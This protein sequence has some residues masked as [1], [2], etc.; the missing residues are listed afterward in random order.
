[1]NAGG[2]AVTRGL[3]VVIVNF[4]SERWIRRA[5]ALAREFGGGATRVIM[6]DNSPGDGAADVARATE[7]NATIITNATNRGY[8]AAV[9]QGLAIGSADTV[10]LLNPDVLRISGRSA[11]VLEAFREPDVAAVVPRLRDTSGAISPSC[12]QTPRLMDF[13]AQDLALA[14]RFPGWKWPRRYRMTDWD[15]ASPRRVDA[16]TGA[17]LF[18]RRAALRD[19]GPFDERFFV[20][21]EETDWLIRA[22]QRGWRTMFL[23]TVEAVHASGASSPGV[24]A[25]P[26]LL[27]LESQHRYA[28]KHFGRAAGVALRATQL[29][30]DAARLVRHALRG[31]TNRTVMARKRIRVHLMMRAPRPS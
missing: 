16:A 13:V 31:N 11:D 17:C 3:D 12:F 6:V 20:Y 29:G 28:E 15:Y 8:A 18:L 30:I 7:R 21:Y 25:Q 26:S 14:A 27:L 1:V 22:T 23:P 9:N 5:I 24:A 19:V 2:A 10:L 4:H